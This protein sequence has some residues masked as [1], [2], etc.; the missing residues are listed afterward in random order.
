M[1]LGHRACCCHEDVADGCGT[2]CSGDG[3]RYYELVL[4]GLSLTACS[5]WEHEY[6]DRFTHYP[7]AKTLRHTANI[8][9]DDDLNNDGAEDLPYL[10]GNNIGGSGGCCWQ[11][12]LIEPLGCAA[13]SVGHISPVPGVCP[14][15]PITSAFDLTAVMWTREDQLEIAI[16]AESDTASFG[17]TYG[18]G[19]YW[20]E[21]QDRWFREANVFCGV[22]PL[23]QPYDCLAERTF[24]NLNTTCPQLM[25]GGTVGTAEDYKHTLATGGTVTIKPMRKIDKVK[26]R[27]LTEDG[28]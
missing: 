2:F 25:T 5:C 27:Y 23:T 24:V 4:S 22:I 19:G 9:I 15:E 10:I 26:G 20:R 8:L 14:V 11:G 17:C 6:F 7:V 13:C 3:S 1:S 12:T 21:I 28:P 16:V 18:S